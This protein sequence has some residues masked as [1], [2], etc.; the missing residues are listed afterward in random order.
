M[1]I[2]VLPDKPDS[3]RFLTDNFDFRQWENHTS[4]IGKKCSF[5]LDKVPTEVPREYEQVIGLTRLGFGFRNDGNTRT[6]RE[7]SK[8]FL[9][10]LRDTFEILRTKIAKLQDDVAFGRCTVAHNLLSR[11]P[12]FSK[13]SRQFGTMLSHRIA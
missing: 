7:S 2:S 13:E 10:H 11:R 6:G 1:K 12:Q 8:L 9:V 3:L 5:T 4:A